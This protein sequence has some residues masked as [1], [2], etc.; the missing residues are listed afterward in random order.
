MATGRIIKYDH[1]EEIMTMFTARD[2]LNPRVRD[3]VDKA[4]S[5]LRDIA[6]SGSI[7]VGEEIMIRTLMPIDLLG[8]AAQRWISPALAANAWTQ[9]L[10]I[11]PTTAQAVA[12]FGVFNRDTNPQVTAFRYGIGTVVGAPV[13]THFPFDD[14]FIEDQPVAYHTPVFFL[15]DKPIEIDLY[16]L[17]AVTQRF[18]FKGLIVEKSASGGV[19]GVKV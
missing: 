14:S 16:S 10:T 9:Y 13:L 17:A 2:M 19:I 4:L 12:I 5:G 11:T 1:P 7:G 3:L 6:K 15:P 8:G 18:G